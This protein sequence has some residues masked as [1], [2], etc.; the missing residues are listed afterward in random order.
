MSAAPLRLQRFHPAPLTASTGNS[1]ARCSTSARTPLGSDSTST[2]TS[3]TPPADSRIRWAAPRVRPLAALAW[4]HHLRA[5]SAPVRRATSRMVLCSGASVFKSA[6]TTNRSS[7]LVL[8]RAE[9]HPKRPV[10]QSNRRGK[11]GHRRQRRGA[12]GARR[13]D[14]PLRRSLGRNGGGDERKKR[15]KA[16]NCFCHETAT[17]LPRF[18]HASTTRRAGKPFHPVP[19]NSAAPPANH[20]RPILPRFCRLCRRNAPHPPAVTQISAP[21]PSEFL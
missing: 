4:R 9:R 13:A 6:A 18:C 7:A 8:N 20:H 12:V 10:A 11:T 19:P 17:I 5:T 3:S 21:L 2:A 14:A 16:R 1:T 15:A